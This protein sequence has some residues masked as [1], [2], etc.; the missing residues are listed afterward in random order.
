MM[1]NKIVEDC[2]FHSLH[3]G[4]IEPSEPLVV[5][6]RSNQ[7]NQSMSIELFLQCNE[8]GLI[9]KAR[10]K[11][12]GNPYVIAAMECLCRKIEAKILGNLPEI[13]YQDLVKELEIPT[14]QYPL[15]LGVVDVYKE[16]L[17]LM[18]KKLEG[19]KS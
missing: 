11:T 2:F 7:H 10:F 12:N 4:S 19:Y 3:A 1:Y 15:A 18:K 5:Y 6:F 14:S 8:S 17:V 9:T 13:N 16:V